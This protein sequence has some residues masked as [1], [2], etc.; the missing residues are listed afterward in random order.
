MNPDRDNLSPLL[1]GAIVMGIEALISQD[2]LVALDLPVVSRRRDPRA[3]VPA[4]QC[5][6]LRLDP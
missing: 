2:P 4:G 5:P 6:I 3:L 1:L